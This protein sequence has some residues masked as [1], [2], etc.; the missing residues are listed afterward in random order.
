MSYASE[1]PTV[2][3]Q[4]RCTQTVG[5]SKW[6]RIR[7]SKA[8]WFFGLDG[9]AYCPEHVPNWVAEWRAGRA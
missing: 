4:P 6:D 7:A 1:N 8:G 9:N 3:A 2:C 5:G